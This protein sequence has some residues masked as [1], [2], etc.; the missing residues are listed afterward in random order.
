MSDSKRSIA[1]IEMMMPAER[2]LAEQPGNRIVF[3]G[4]GLSIETPDGRVSVTEGGQLAAERAGRRGYRRKTPVIVRILDTSAPASLSYR[5]MLSE[6]DSAFRE[7]M[8]VVGDGP[9]PTVV[10]LVTSVVANRIMSEV[11]GLPSRDRF[12]SVEGVCFATANE[13]DGMISI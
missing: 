13:F 5:E 10:W 6:Q 4:E 11:A 12:R 3:D 1:P 7:N 2:L 8:V 9:R